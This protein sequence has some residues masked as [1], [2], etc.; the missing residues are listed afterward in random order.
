MI[1]YTIIFF[2][3][4]IFLHLPYQKII[5]IKIFFDKIKKK[6][7]FLPAIA[8]ICRQFPSIAVNWWQLPASYIQ[9]FST[10]NDWIIFF[11]FFFKIIKFLMKEFD[12]NDLIPVEVSFCQNVTKRLAGY[13]FAFY[14]LFKLLN[15]NKNWKSYFRNFFFLMTRRCII[16]WN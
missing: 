14:F 5:K 10:V 1:L 6:K 2:A 15:C 12:L 13:I 4:R 11:Y 9:K 3:A 7:K 16:K 8:D